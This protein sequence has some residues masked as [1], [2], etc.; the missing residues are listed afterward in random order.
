MST[1]NPSYSDHMN[2][3]RLETQFVS[4]ASMSIED[5]YMHY[6]I[7]GLQEKDKDLPSMNLAH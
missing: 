1:L 6:D 3:C 7:A 5:I 4:L 2:T